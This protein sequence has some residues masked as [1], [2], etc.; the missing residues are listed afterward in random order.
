LGFI[1]RQAVAF[2]C[3]AAIRPLPKKSYL[4]TYGRFFGF[5]IL[6]QNQGVNVKE[7]ADGRKMEAEKCSVFMFLTPFF[8]LLPFGGRKTGQHP[9]IITHQPPQP[10]SGVIYDTKR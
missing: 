7:K 9:T 3:L 4:K 10:P 8:C 1:A 2:Q 5:S 6:C